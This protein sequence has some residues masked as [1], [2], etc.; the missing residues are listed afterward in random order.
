MPLI[1]SSKP[2]E[3][4]SWWIRLLCRQWQL[5][6]SWCGLLWLLRLP[7]RLGLLYRWYLLPKGRRVLYDWL[8][9]PSRN[10]MC[11]CGRSS[12]VCCCRRSFTT[13]NYCGTANYYGSTSCSLRILLLYHHLV[14]L[15]MIQLWGFLTWYLGG[16][17]NGT[18]PGITLLKKS[19]RLS[20][21]PLQLHYIPLYPSMKAILRPQ[22]HHFNL[23]RRLFRSL[24]QLCGQIPSCPAR[25]YQSRA[26]LRMRRLHRQPPWRPP[27]KLLRTQ[28]QLDG[29]VLTPSWSLRGF[30]LHR[31][32]WWSCYDSTWRLQN[33]ARNVI[34]LLSWSIWRLHAAVLH[35]E[36]QFIMWIIFNTFSFLDYLRNPRYTIY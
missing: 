3:L 32:F 14:G 28:S 9:L 25:P 11:A 1:L 22:W 18:T 24:L 27:Q 8:L 10:Y 13:H 7:C 36:S 21:P 17:L 19:M 5:S 15:R 30:L 4:L 33:R 34:I 6:R 31:A 29:Q 23:F 20:S 12:K 16:M 2:L 26:P 35:S